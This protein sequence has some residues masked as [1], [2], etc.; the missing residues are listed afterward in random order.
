MTISTDILRK[1]AQVTGSESIAETQL[2]Q[3]LWGEDT[4]SFSEPR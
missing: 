3:S 2:I 1:V 4:V